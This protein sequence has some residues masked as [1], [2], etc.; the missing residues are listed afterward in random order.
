MVT[1]T[2]LCI[3]SLSTGVPDYA[4]DPSVPLVGRGRDYIENEID[5]SRVKI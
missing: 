4:V 5:S 3:K 2:F 1:Y